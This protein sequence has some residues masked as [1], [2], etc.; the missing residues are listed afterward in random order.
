MVSRNGRF[1]IGEIHGRL[2][3]FILQPS[4]RDAIQRLPKTDPAASLIAD[5][6]RVIPVSHWTFARLK[7]NDSASDFLGS[8]AR[9]SERS[10]SLG[11]LR[12]E[13]VLQREQTKKGPR[14]S[15]T[16]GALPEGY[17]R[18]VTLVFAGGR[19]ELGILS[20]LRTEDLG[21]FTSA[22]LRLLALALD[23]SADRLAGFPLI[24]ITPSAHH[25]EGAAPDR[26]AGMYVLDEA[27]KIV[28]AWNAAE[29]REAAITNARTH[30]GD[31]LPPVI[32]SAVAELISQWTSDPASQSG[33]VRPVPFLLVRASHLSGP[34]G[35][36][37]GVMLERVPGANALTGAGDT[38]ALTP[39]ELQTLALLLEGLSLEEI[40]R[41]MHI[42]STTVQDHIK[43]MLEKTNSKNRSEMIAKIVGMQY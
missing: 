1:N 35:A 25:L 37:V 13:F 26:G 19:R 6:L 11:R 17:A 9:G 4:D 12:I 15:P 16:L 10:A 39:R 34:S 14:L 24:E 20:L 23:S 33:E 41:S 29:G 40:G 42:Q 7:D 21:P 2:E 32:E 30:L 22:E 43:N 5:I 27:L 31:R 28:L 18:G 8:D 38:F 3:A 36:F